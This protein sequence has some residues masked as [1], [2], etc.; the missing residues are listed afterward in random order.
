MPKVFTGEVVIPGDKI[1]EYFQLLAAAEETRQPFREYL[2]GLNEEFASQP[3][4]GHHQ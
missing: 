4:E 1:E 2:E 3:G